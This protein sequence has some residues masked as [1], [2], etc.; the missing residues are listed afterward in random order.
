MYFMKAKVA[1]GFSMLSVLAGGLLATS[2]ASAQECSAERAQISA[3]E[4]QVRDLQRQLGQLPAVSAPALGDIVSDAIGVQNMTHIAADAY[5]H[6]HGSR[7]PTARELALVAISHG[8]C[9]ILSP[10]DYASYEGTERCPKSHYYRRT[11]AVST[12]EP[13]GDDF[14]FSADG[15]QRPRGEAGNYYWFWSSSV[16]AGSSGYA[17]VLYGYDGAFEHHFRSPFDGFHA[18]RCVR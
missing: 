8:A 1:L 12:Q 9:G 13:A 5:C 7:L 11:V 6:G 4:I 3:L 15:Y 18:V 2:S 17:Y 16:R 14:Y 10:S